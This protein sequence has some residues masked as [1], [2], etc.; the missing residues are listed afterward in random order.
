MP[1]MSSIAVPAVTHADGDIPA[2]TYKPISRNG[3][4]AVWGQDGVSEAIARPAM[5]L[6]YSPATS[7]RSTD[8][9]TLSF[10]LPLARTSEGS[11]VVDDVARSEITLIIP[12]SATAAERHRM[13]HD[14]SYIT[15]QHD[16]LMDT[17]EDLTFFT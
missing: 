7:K 5:T 4:K 2:H 9:Y 1:T 13:V 10:A 14:I 11:T 16:A 6:S 17:V 3:Y 15:T 8:R 12:T